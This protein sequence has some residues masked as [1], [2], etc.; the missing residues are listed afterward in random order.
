MEYSSELNNMTKNLFEK[1]MKSN[2]PVTVL[3]KRLLRRIKYLFRLAENN[4][5]QKSF[6]NVIQA[7]RNYTE[8]SENLKN[9]E[10]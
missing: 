5:K 8:I 4:S 9:I 7:L 3:Q 2:P 6:D 1:T 10:K